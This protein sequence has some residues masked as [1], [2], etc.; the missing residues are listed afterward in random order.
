VTNKEGYEYS[1]WGNL[2]HPVFD[3]EYL[4]SVEEIEWWNAK[5]E[6]SDDIINS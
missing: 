4:F 6:E 2:G 5:E 1:V 3:N